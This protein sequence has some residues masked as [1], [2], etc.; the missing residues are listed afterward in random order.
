MQGS[1]PH[2]PGDASM[3]GNASQVASDPLEQLGLLP[4]GQA[5]EKFFSVVERAHG[6]DYT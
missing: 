6:T 1:P 5:R 3:P 4:A 2:T